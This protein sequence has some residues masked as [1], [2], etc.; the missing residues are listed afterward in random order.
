MLMRKNKKFVAVMVGLIIIVLLF[1]V[2]AIVA[3]YTTPQPTYQ[4]PAQDIE[5]VINGGTDTETVIQWST[6]NVWEE[7][8]EGQV[9]NNAINSDS[10][11]QPQDTSESEVTIEE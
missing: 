8:V 11:E 3:L 5:A 1:S 9:E 4:I 6:F 7:N 2:I 10:D